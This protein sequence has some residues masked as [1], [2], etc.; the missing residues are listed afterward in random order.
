MSGQN[1]QSGVVFLKSNRIILR[2]IERTDIPQIIKWVNDPD[3]RQYISIIFPMMETDEQEWFDNLH[4]RK[5]NDMVF[6]IVVDEKF[7]GNMGVHGISWTNGTATT[8][9]FIGEKEYRGKG[10]GTEAKMLLLH[11]L[12]HT[13]N[14][15]KV[16]S[17]VIAYN[18]RSYAYSMKCWYKEEGRR[19]AQL[20]RKG[21]Y[22]DEVLLAVFREDWEPLWEVFA[23][24][25]NL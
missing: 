19:K 16:C 17:T 5:P 23:R 11:Y 6:G 22:W 7:I 3:V 20:Y 13:L 1:T 2:P 24:E 25:H 18:K 8:G 4:R 21:Q 14:L 12:F 10:Y 9:A 15:H